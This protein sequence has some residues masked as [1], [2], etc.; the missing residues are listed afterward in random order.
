MKLSV[1]L[2]N[3]QIEWLMA[4]KGDY[5]MAKFVSKLVSDQMKQSKSTEDYNE[6]NAVPINES[7]S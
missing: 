1:G 3:E 4:N 2:N 5:S 7:N 6:I